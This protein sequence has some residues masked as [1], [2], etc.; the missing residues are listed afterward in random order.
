MNKFERECLKTRIMRLASLKCT[1][2]PLEMADKFEIS[3]RS[4]KRLVKELRDDGQE[5]F[6]NRLQQSY[7]MKKKS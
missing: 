6:Y 1:G 5:I 2:T 3:V 7:V 4:V